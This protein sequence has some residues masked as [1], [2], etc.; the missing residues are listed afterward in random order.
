MTSFVRMQS[1]FQ[2]KNNITNPLC[3]Q[4]DVVRS[5]VTKALG[6]VDANIRRNASS[7]VSAAVRNGAWPVNVIVPQLVG[8]LQEA[9]FTNPAQAHGSVVA[10]SHVVEDAI[11]ALDAANFSSLVVNA[12]C[13][14]V[15][16]EGNEKIRLNALIALS[17]FLEQAGIYSKGASYLA[18]HPVIVQLMECFLQN[19]Q[20]P[21]SSDISEKSIKCLVLSLSFH[22]QITQDL[23]FRV[24][25]VMLQATQVDP[26]TMEAVRIEAVQFWQGVLHFPTFAE[27]IFP[28]LG[29]IVP[30]LVDGMVY[31]KMELGMLQANAEDAN[32]PDR[33]EDLKPRHYE[34]RT[35]A[36]AE[37]DEDD[38]DSD[39]V[40][41][42]NL[43]RVS[44]VTLDDIAEN[45][46][47]RV[48]DSVLGVIDQR[49]QPSQDWRPLEAAVLALGAIAEGCYEGL[50]PYLEAITGRLLDLLENSSTHFLVVSIATWALRRLAQFLLYASDGSD[51]RPFLRRY[52]ATILKHM[53][54]S[55]KLV[56][57]AACCALTDVCDQA[58]DGQVD[59]YLPS[60]AQTVH[61]C[62][63][64]YQLKNK[65]LLF[66]QIQ[67]LCNRFQQQIAAPEVMPLFINP[68]VTIW[69]QTPNDS[70]ILFSFF[71]CM[72]S[73]CGAV[74]PHIQ[75][76][77]KDIFDR[78]F[79]VY[80]F[81]MNVRATALQTGEEPSEFEYIV[82]SVDLLSG[83]F[84]ALG[85]SLEPLVQASN[86]LLMQITLAALVDENHEI[87]QAGFALLGDLAKSCPRYVQEALPQVIQAIGQNCQEL[88]EFTAGC[89][90][91]AAWCAQEVLD[92]QMDIDQLPLL[93]GP[94][95]AHAASQLLRVLAQGE[96]TADMKN[97]A[98]NIAIFVGSAMHADANLLQGVGVTLDQFLRRWLDH[99]RHIRKGDGRLNAARGVLLPLQQNPAMLCGMVTMF[100]DYCSTLCQAP[101]DIRKA[102]SSIMTALSQGA[103]VEWAQAVKSYSPQ[104][105]NEL[106][107]AFG[108]R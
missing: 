1:G 83:L 90:S 38:D 93:Q 102:V 55:S 32:V 51:G 20:N 65:V 28:A 17:V 52:M 19:L 99:A 14:C 26:D 81:H 41:D 107:V 101:D 48:L 62:L 74:G 42:Y 10:L 4:N 64:G 76:M 24:A 58:E 105:L 106:Y 29:Q 98:E 37:D 36:M 8:M 97:M 73:V 61:T 31:S 80:S 3:I 91:N 5:N 6:D 103:Q 60:I 53:Q 82:T 23:F 25:Q 59:A 9:G 75:P 92:H 69:Q 34:A 47:D 56:Q 86:P 104:L 88:N 70:P 79:A 54:A 22:E 39:E 108:V 44:A 15:M 94:T 7:V 13:P 35:Q 11:E 89:I 96:L 84:D 100:L 85:S 18:L 72:S 87:R 49:M 16:Y 30:L 45:F 46:G 77:A 63:G 2:L 68:L 21:M 27:L 71:K 57:E 40:E 78:A 43:R 67:S 50:K 95:L 12:L 66:E 33:L